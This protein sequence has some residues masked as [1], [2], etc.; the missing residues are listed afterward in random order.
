M[1]VEL[2]EDGSDQRLIIIQFLI[3]GS[4]DYEIMMMIEMWKVWTERAV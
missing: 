4:D 1:L 3:V 2:W